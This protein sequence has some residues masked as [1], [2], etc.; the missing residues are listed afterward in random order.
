MRENEGVFARIKQL[1]SMV[2]ASINRKSM[3]RCLKR[4]DVA[5]WCSLIPPQKAAHFPSFSA[6]FRSFSLISGSKCFK[7]VSTSLI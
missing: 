4:D 7:E 5:V 6:Y 1:M 3:K 2:G